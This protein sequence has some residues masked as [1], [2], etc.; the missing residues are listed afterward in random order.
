MPKMSI[1]FAPRSL[2]QLWN[3]SLHSFTGSQN[4]PTINAINTTAPRT[5][6]QVE[7]TDFAVPELL[8]HRSPGSHCQW[9]EALCHGEIRMVV[10]SG[11]VAVRHVGTVSCCR[12]RRGDPLSRTAAWRLKPIAYSAATSRSFAR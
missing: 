11:P 9:H 1:P 12:T 3:E 5:H 4:H 7:E 6:F 10:S 2:I 8:M